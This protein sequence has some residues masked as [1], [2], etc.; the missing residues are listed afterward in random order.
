MLA[1][2][3]PWDK[4]V[5]DCID[6]VSWVRQNDYQKTPWCKIENTALSLLRNILTYDPTAR[7]T[8]RQIKQSTWFLKIYRATYDPMSNIENQ[9]FLSQPIHFYLNNNTA[10]SA[11]I[12][13]KSTQ[14]MNILNTE[15]EVTDSQ[16]NCECSYQK[17]FE[18]FSQPIS[19]ENMYLNTQT[20]LTQ[21]QVG[22]I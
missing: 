12:D 21:T 9:G 13:D 20:G 1:G 3:L 4:P 7:F 8:M 2:E 17:S 19:T 10:S 5:M 18:S 15:L 16:H 6:F 22:Q 11:T 14:M